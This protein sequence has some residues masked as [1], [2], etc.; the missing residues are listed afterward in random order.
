MNNLR[1]R[2]TL[3]NLTR[4]SSG[5]EARAGRLAEAEEAA[6]ENVRSVCLRP[7][8]PVLLASYPSSHRILYTEEAAGGGH[9]A[10][11]RGSLLQRQD[12]EGTCVLLQFVAAVY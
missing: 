2:R 10:T 6:E 9:R 4:L 12:V 8:S 7:G 11:T 1:V 3:S 5:G